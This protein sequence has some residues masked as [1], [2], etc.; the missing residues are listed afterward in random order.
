MK[1]AL[2]AS[3]IFALGFI[4]ACGGGGGGG[5]TP[6]AGGGSSN[7]GRETSGVS[8]GGIV[9]SPA[10]V[11]VRGRITSFQK[12]GIQSLKPQQ[13]GCNINGI[14]L[15][16]V[17]AVSI[18]QN[19][20]LTAAGTQVG[21]DCSFNFSLNTALRYGFVVFDDQRRALALF[22]D[23]AGRNVFRF[24]GNVNLTATLVD[25]NGDGIPEIAQVNVDN[26]QNVEV[27]SDDNFGTLVTN[28]QRYDRNGNGIPDFMDDFN[29]NGLPDSMEDMNNNG[30]PDSLEDWDHNGIVEGFEDENRNYV[31]DHVEDYDM[32]GHP[33]HYECD[34]DDKFED[35]HEGEE[36]YRCFPQPQ[37]PAGGTPG[38]QQG[39]N[40]GGGNQGGG[41]QGGN[42]GGG[43]PQTVSFS[44]DVMPILQQS[45]SGCHQVNSGAGN[46]RLSY[47]VIVNGSPATPGYTSFID[48][49]NPSQSL[50]LLKATNQ[51][52]HGGGQVIAPNSQAYQTILRWIQEGAPNN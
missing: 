21:S 24:R 39:G 9:T 40:Q 12:V 3:G 28:P 52:G 37:P 47:N 19:G 13:A 1:K 34:Y 42:Q 45:C 49:N 44:R 38:G 15:A 18:D 20:N 50:I 29:G 17:V 32:D 11:N 48:T 5:G 51:V 41:N 6:T 22:T 36:R 35:E 4:V 23:P 43:A 8:S 2:L 33:E 26:P 30:Y 46:F 16:Y 7:V 25:T 10:F 27:S 31:P 14:N